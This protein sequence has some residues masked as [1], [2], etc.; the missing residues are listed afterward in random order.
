[1]TSFHTKAHENR[2]PRAECPGGRRMAGNNQDTI[3]TLR[4]LRIDFTAI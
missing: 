4:E 2:Q 1:M 3:R